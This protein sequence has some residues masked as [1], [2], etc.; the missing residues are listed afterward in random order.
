MELWK[1]FCVIFLHHTPF[2]RDR[3]RKF[4]Q[5]RQVTGRHRFLLPASNSY[6]R[7]RIR[8]QGSVYGLV[9]H[10]VPTLLGPQKS[11][12]RKP[13]TVPLTGYL[14]CGHGAENTPRSVGTSD[15]H[16][17]D[18]GGISDD[19]EIVCNEAVLSKGKGDLASTKQPNQTKHTQRKKLKKL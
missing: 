1:R 18:S 4:R 12:R 19:L 3:E 9:E 8:L 6:Q 11:V 13:R 17:T 15:Q 7:H 16:G 2:S 10:T 14:L 5:Y